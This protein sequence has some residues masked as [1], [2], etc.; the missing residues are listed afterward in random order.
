MLPQKSY[1]AVSY[2]DI[3]TL[4]FTGSIKVSFDNQNVFAAFQFRGILE[5][6][7]HIYVPKGLN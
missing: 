2:F 3:A 7:I 5:A 6:E 1:G 4:D